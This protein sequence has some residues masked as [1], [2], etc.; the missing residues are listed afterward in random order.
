M[1]NEELII[2]AY[3][4]SEDVANKSSISMNV[5]A[6]SFVIVLLIVV[7]YYLWN[8]KPEEPYVPSLDEP[9]NQPIE[10]EDVK[11]EDIVAEWDDFG[12][13]KNF[14]YAGGKKLWEDPS[15]VLISAPEEDLLWAQM[16]SN[17]D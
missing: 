12:A 2:E 17:M 14:E 7:I 11:P 15:A 6:F 13:V 8:D 16:Y 10:I 9:K 1:D 4:P 5:V 3:N